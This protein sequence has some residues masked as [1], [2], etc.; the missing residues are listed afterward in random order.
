MNSMLQSNDKEYQNGL[1][2]TRPINMLLRRDYF[3]LFYFI[4]FYFI[5]FYFILKILF[6]YSWETERERE[7]G[8]D[9]GRGKLCFF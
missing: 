8:R 1:K 9:T 6:I 4:L 3:I 2:K 5:L 7:R